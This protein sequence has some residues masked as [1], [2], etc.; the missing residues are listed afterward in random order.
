MLGKGLQSDFISFSSLLLLHQI[1]LQH[2]LCSDIF[3]CLLI[4]CIKL[5]QL[6]TNFYIYQQRR[7]ISE[8][9]SAERER[10]VFAN[11]FLHSLD[12]ASGSKYKILPN[13]RNLVRSYSQSIEYLASM[14]LNEYFPVHNCSK[15]N[16]A[17]FT[18]KALHACEMVH[19]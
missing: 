18:R 17:E 8:D 19:F 14:P 4:F 3:I 9:S 7:E 1:E 2:R 10:R 6:H 15:D 16:K 11:M 13:S 12:F 5:K